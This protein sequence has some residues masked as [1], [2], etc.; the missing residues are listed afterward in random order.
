MNEI[1][2]RMNKIF[3]AVVSVLNFSQY[4][5]LEEILRKIYLGGILDFIYM[6]Y[7]FLMSFVIVI[8]TSQYIKDWRWLVA[9]GLSVFFIA[10]F[11]LVPTP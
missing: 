2:H 1:L 9:I 8:E 5:R 7:P 3:G 4:T 11:I 6:A 10:K